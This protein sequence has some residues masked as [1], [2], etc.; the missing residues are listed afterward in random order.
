MPRPSAEVDKSYFLQA[1]A[2][3]L[4][5][6]GVP[7]WVEVPRGSHRH[8]DAGPTGGPVSG[9]PE[10]ESHHQKRLDA[11]R[12]RNP[13]VP[14]IPT[15]IPAGNH[16]AARPFSPSSS[17]LPQNCEIWRSVERAISALVDPEWSE[18]MT[19]DAF[20]KDMMRLLGTGVWSGRKHEFQHHHG[21][22]HPR[23]KERERWLKVRD[24]VQDCGHKGALLAAVEIPNT[25]CEP[26]SYPLDFRGVDVGPGALRCPLELP[27]PGVSIMDWYVVEVAGFEKG[28]EAEAKA[29]FDA[30]HSTGALGYRW[31]LCKVQNKDESSRSIRHSRY[32]VE[33]L[34]K[35]VQE[36]VEAAS[37]LKLDFPQLVVNESSCVGMDAAWINLFELPIDWVYIAAL[38]NRRLLASRQQELL[39]L[40]PPA[41]VPPT[42]SD[43]AS[44]AERA[45]AERSHLR[46]LC[47]WALFEYDTKHPPAVQRAATATS[48]STISHSLSSPLVRAAVSFSQLKTLISLFHRFAR[49]KTCP[50]SALSGSLALRLPPCLLTPT[51]CMTRCFGSKDWRLFFKHANAGPRFHRACFLPTGHLIEPFC[52]MLHP[53]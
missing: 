32:Q 48:I 36:Q 25:W 50:S 5:R 34:F 7:L 46:K 47:H 42:R 1:R 49:R 51:C 8:Y 14:M 22:I 6:W 24:G 2:R 40:A 44:P 11:L 43:G 3:K 45:D 23:S 37:R 27:R 39:A 20:N 30:Y 41:S 52:T 26:Q 21:Q 16:T 28:D 17:P 31:V 35:A 13:P 33:V 15:R 12:R 10:L 53:L 29:I 9:L 38:F 4:E 18:A 19:F